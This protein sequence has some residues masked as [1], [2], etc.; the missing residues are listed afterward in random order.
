MGLEAPHQ[1]AQR[2]AVMSAA[3]LGRCCLLRQQFSVTTQRPI[4]A[5]RRWGDRPHRN[6]SNC[7]RHT[8]TCRA[9]SFAAPIQHAT[10][11]RCCAVVMGGWGESMPASVNW[12]RR[13]CSANAASASGGSFASQDASAA[14]ACLIC[15]GS[16]S[17]TLL[18]HC[19]R[20]SATAITRHSSAVA[21]PPI[22]CHGRS[23][24]T[25][26]GTRYG[27]RAIRTLIRVPRL[28]SLEENG[29]LQD[30]CSL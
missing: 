23:R 13:N 2:S 12:N 30:D 26:L 22:R 9:V 10:P 5:D 24:E 25:Q 27:L 1:Q 15:S 7:W 6:G 4:A 16:S 29:A 20:T 14:I 8:L 21:L 18:S 19:K 11:R 3:L 17:Q 28:A